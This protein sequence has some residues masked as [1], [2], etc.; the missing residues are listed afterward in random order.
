MAGVLKEIF[1]TVQLLKYSL[2]RYIQEPPFL[3]SSL[4]ALYR[5]KPFS[6][7]SESGICGFKKVS[8]SNIIA[9]L[10]L[11]TK[12]DSSVNLEVRDSIL[13]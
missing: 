7:T 13:V 10:C 3:P 12:I 9:G 5:V 4:S 2:L 11:T 6:F 8:Q 1:S